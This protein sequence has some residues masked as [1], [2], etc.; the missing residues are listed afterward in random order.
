MTGI[1]Y[2][3]PYIFNRY[4]QLVRLSADADRNG[5]HI[6]KSELPARGIGQRVITAVGKS[7]AF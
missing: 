1:L 6:V 7:E 4:I 3:I 5:R 2:I